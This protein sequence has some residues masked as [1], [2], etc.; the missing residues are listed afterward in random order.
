MKE[1]DEVVYTEPKP[2]HRYKAGE[3]FASKLASKIKPNSQ[4]SKGYSPMR[5]HSKSIAFSLSK[6]LGH[7]TL[8]VRRP[9]EV[10]AQKENQTDLLTEMKRK[11]SCERNNRK[12][13]TRP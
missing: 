3:T 2:K 7:K 11:T 9:V 4:L 6:I 12:S 8:R 1:N 10:K 13:S 5:G